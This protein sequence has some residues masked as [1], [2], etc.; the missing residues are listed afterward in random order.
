MLKQ[1]IDLISD[2]CP[3]TGNSIIDTF[4]FIIIGA[5]AFS[6][7]FGVVGQI[8]DSFGRYD[9]DI[10]SDTHWSIRFIV[11]IVLYCIF[12][13]AATIVKLL[14]SVKWWIYLIVFI[15]IIGII[16]LVHAIR[17]KV[18]NNKNANVSIEQPE[19]NKQL[20]EKQQIIMNNKNVCPRCGGRLVYRHGPYGDFYGC[21]NFSKTGCT[22]T[23]KHK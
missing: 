5:I 17:Y 10:M 18:R 13:F 8:F 14:F 19:S 4:L 9:S 15:V 1:I 20:E 22:Y 7:A 2:L 23:R 16:V 11:F 21:E 3:I 12:V 6:I